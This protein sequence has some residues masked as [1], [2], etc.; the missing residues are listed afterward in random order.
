MNDQSH[1]LERRSLLCLLGAAAL[2]VPATLAACAHS[3]PP[4]QY[5]RPPSHITAKS[6]KD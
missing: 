2:I 4:R 5:K 1:R 3:I 6:L